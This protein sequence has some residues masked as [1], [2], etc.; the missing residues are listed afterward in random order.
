[1]DCVEHMR[2][3]SKIISLQQDMLSRH[4]PSSAHLSSKPAPAPSA[5]DVTHLRAAA[6]LV[7]VPPSVGYSQP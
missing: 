4:R 2:L 5:G 3:V 7:Y 1:M 6:P